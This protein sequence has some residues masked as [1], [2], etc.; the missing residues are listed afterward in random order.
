MQI[1]DILF[2]RWHYGLASGSADSKMRRAR[3]REED[4]H[5]AQASGGVNLLFISVHENGVIRLGMVH[6][7][8][9]VLQSLA[10]GRPNCSVYGVPG[11]MDWKN[12]E[13]MAYLS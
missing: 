3:Y 7:C 1:T 2:K 10:I 13:V 8:V 12:E 9:E 11:P 4:F 6:A 5:R